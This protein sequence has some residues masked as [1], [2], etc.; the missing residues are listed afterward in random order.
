[1][2]RASAVQCQLAVG[3]FVMVPAGSGRICMVPAGM[4]DMPAQCRRLTL[5]VAGSLILGQVSAKGKKRERERERKKKI[6][7]KGERFVRR[8]TE[9]SEHRRRDRGRRVMTW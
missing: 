5:K 9:P 1:M 7:R 6:K 4:G 3:A 8:G 2:G